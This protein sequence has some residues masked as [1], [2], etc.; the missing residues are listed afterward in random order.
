MLPQKSPSKV[1]SK[2]PTCEPQQFGT[3]LNPVR[4]CGWSE[5]FINILLVVASHPQKNSGRGNG[6]L[7]QWQHVIK[8]SLPYLVLLVL[9]PPFL[10]YFLH[11]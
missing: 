2:V 5:Q 9:T 7:Q 4:C 10:Q 1:A 8:Y 6:R 11:W 3:C